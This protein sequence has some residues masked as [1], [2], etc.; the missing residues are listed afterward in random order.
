MNH[1]EPLPRR[2]GLLDSTNVVLG[3]MIGSAVFLVPNTIAQNMPS[4]PLTI[5]MWVLAGIVSMIGGLAYAELGTMMPAAGGQYVYLRRAW[6]PMWGFLCGWTFLLVARTGATA[7]VAAAFSIYLSRFIP[8]PVITQRLVAAALILGLAAVNCRGV[9]WGAGVQNFFT[10]LKLLGLALLIGS[11]LTSPAHGVAQPDVSFGS[12]TAVQI[13]TALTPCIFAYNGWFAIGMLGGEVKNP[14][15]NMPLGII[16]GVTIAMTVFVLANV[17]YVRTMTLAEIA[18]APR[19]AEA[20]AAKAMGAIGAT[21]VAATIIVSTFGTTN[22]NVMTGPRVFFAQASDGLFFEPFARVHPRWQT[23]YIA[24]MGSATWAAILVL[25]GTYIQLIAYAT[26]IFWVL[27]GMTVAG[28]IVLRVREPDAV[29]PYR[30]PGYPVTPA[31]FVLVAIAV[32]VF[33]FIS[34]PGTSAI[35]LGIFLAGIPAFYGWQ[36]WRK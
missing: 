16:F 26:F 7:A 22:G 30:M 33:T 32:S 3:T 9:R 4:V 10:G 17:G 11:T 5:G 6:G 24:I 25:S 14:D 31:I 27:Y 15:R 36:A 8:M 20:A 23:P 19:V 21:I 29:R 2:L 13:G 35:G 28:L 34:S 1:Q 12:L 18:A